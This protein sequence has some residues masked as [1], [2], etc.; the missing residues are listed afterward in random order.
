MDDVWL[1]V[2]QEAKVRNAQLFIQERLESLGLRINVA[3]THAYS[4][5]KLEEAARE[6]EHSAADHSLDELED[7]GPL[8]E[9][10]EHIIADPTE[11]PRTTIKFVIFIPGIRRSIEIPPS[12]QLQGT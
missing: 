2:S 6:I 7:T 8:E 12:A 11:S 10:L 5:N 9:L 4:G 3:K 1:F